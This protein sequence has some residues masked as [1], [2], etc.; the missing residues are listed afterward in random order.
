MPKTSM[1]GNPVPMPALTAPDCGDRM[2]TEQPIITMEDDGREF[3]R[4]TP[5]G[6][7]RCAHEGYEKARIS[8]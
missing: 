4:L 7:L 5:D 2:E 6:I 3:Y 1:P 8:S